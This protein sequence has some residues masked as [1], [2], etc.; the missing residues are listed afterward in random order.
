MSGGSFG[1]LYSKPPG[2]KLAGAIENGDAIEAELLQVLDRLDAAAEISASIKNHSVTA[3]RAATDHE[4]LA[5]LS[6]LAKFKDFL[7]RARP[8]LEEVKKFDRLLHAVEWFASADYGPEGVVRELVE[9]LEEQLG[10]K[11]NSPRPS[12]E[13]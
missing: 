4:R 5:V 7:R 9:D 3:M 2:E 6:G 10:M 8:L 12:R 1:Y 11:L 13:P